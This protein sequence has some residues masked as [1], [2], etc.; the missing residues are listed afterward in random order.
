MPE[1]IPTTYRGITMRSRLEAGWAATLDSYSIEWHYE[2]HLLKLASGELYLPDFWL[3]AL[4]TVLEAKG[5][6][7]GREHKPAEL[8][9]ELPWDYIVLLGFPPARRTAGPYQPYF[10]MKWRDAAGYDT[11]FARCLQCSA[12]QW[13]RPQLSAA[14]RV[15]AEPVRGL[16]ARSDE[17]KFTEAEP[18]PDL[19]YLFGRQ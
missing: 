12:W 5:P 15:C 17:M 3:P 8:A 13:L 2:P 16:L 7:V 11:R 14:C 4:G 1:S 6:L 18:E 19:S 9:I 10:T